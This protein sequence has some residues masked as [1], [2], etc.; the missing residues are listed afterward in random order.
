MREVRALLS[1]QTDE[2]AAE[3][4]KHARFLELIAEVGPF[5]DPASA[6]ESLLQ[7]RVMAIATIPQQ[8]ELLQAAKND[9]Q[10]ERAA[11]RD[12]RR[13]VAQYERLVTRA[14]T[15]LERLGP[16]DEDAAPRT[17]NQLV[18]A[19]VE[20]LLER[21]EV[22][23]PVAPVAPVIPPDTPRSQINDITP[24]PRRQDRGAW[25]DRVLVPAGAVLLALIFLGFLLEH[26]LG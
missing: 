14:L 10:V 6:V 19:A 9:I 25:M 1:A 22:A 17:L 26:L 13:A 23:A 20:E 12:G 21:R 16:A 8:A 24:R 15:T 18:G 5:A 7:R 11:A 4:K 2:L 3:K